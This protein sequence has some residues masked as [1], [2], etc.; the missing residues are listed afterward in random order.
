MQKKTY[1]VNDVHMI[2][3]R[4]PYWSRSNEP[5]RAQAV[6]A[7]HQFHKIFP[8]KATNSQ[9]HIIHLC[10]RQ[11]NSLWP[12]I[13]DTTFKM[14]SNDPIFSTRK[15]SIRHQRR[16]AHY[17]SFILLFFNARSIMALIVGAIA[18]K[19]MTKTTFHRHIT[20]RMLF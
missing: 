17:F 16:S 5:L 10:C 18:I 3:K 8:S 6:E 20:A 12:D 9:S 4:S 11:R 7:I 1:C 19:W 14:R 2:A 13:I 15:H